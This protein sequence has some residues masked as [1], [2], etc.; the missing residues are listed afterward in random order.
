M[1]SV[2]KLFALGAIVSVAPCLAGNSAKN[3]FDPDADFS[4]FSTFAFIG[5]HELEKTGILANPETRERFKNFISGAL[6]MR[7][8]S[9]VPVDAKPTLAVRYWVAFRQKQDVSVIDWGAASWWGGYPPYWTGV[10]GYSYEEYVV[11]NYVQGTLIIDVI[12]PAT[13]DLVW[14]VFL[15]QKIEDRAKAYKEAKKNL[16][17]AIAVWPPSAEEK[18]KMR[19]SR[20]K[21]EARYAREMQEG[22]GK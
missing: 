15:R 7:G 5:G 3:D 17:N 6:E 11:S 13:K 8:L 14:R 21:L 9:E 12:N 2:F 18:E 10:W 20:A 4:K 19:Q 16:Y 22:K 1:N